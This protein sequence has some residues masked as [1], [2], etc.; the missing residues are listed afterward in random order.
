MIPWQQ[1]NSKPN[2]E[3]NKVLIHLS[4]KGSKLQAPLAGNTAIKNT[5]M[6]FNFNFLDK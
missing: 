1:L 5:W 3:E 6:D 4:S 2:K